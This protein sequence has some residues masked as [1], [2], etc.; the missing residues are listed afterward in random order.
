MLP[1]R[2]AD[3]M[4]RAD[5]VA[6]DGEWQFREDPADAGERER[7]FATPLKA[8]TITVPGA[9]QA[10]FEELHTF[11]G[12]GWYQKSFPLPAG[13]RGKHVY[14]LFESVK[15]TARVWF[16]GQF[17]GEHVGGRTP[18]RVEIS[19]LIQPAGEN[20]LTVRAFD[21]PFGVDFVEDTH[22]L[23]HSSGI[24][25]HVS[26]ITTGRAYVSDLFIE[27]DLDR[28]QATAHLT[29]GVWGERVPARARV[30]LIVTSPSGDTI[31]TSERRVSLPASETTQVDMPV[32]ITPLLTWD[33][34]HPHL[35]MASVSLVG[36]RNEVYDQVSVTFGMRKIE[37][38][39]ERACTSI[40]SRFSWSWA[41][42][43]RDAGQH[44][45]G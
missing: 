34:E 12:A 30:K 1:D 2:A 6:L 28:A 23:V 36:E 41:A 38:R 42:R 43:R 33:L 3:N 14:L 27:P 35:Y 17:V 18:F 40:T 4:Q 32:T 26:V 16:N 45:A 22:A 5:S 44:R 37:V 15:H 8:R 25:G 10:A 20:L 21:P 13:A 9:W 29:I 11:Q 24:L 19:H 39:G 31:D 7:W